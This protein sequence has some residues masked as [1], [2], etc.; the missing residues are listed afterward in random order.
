MQIERFQWKETSRIV[1]MICQ[2]WKLDRMFKS[3]KIQTA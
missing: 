2:V 3:L 1:E